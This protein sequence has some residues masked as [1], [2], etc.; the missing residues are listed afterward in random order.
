[1]EQVVCSLDSGT[2][3]QFVMIINK[4]GCNENFVLGHALTHALAPLGH[5]L[6]HELGHDLHDVV[7]VVLVGL[8][9]Q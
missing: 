3:F 6:G 5:E 7:L 4:F 9:V 8:I 2:L 1:M